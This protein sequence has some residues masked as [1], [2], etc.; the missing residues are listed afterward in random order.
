MLEYVEPKCLR[1][2]RSAETVAIK[3]SADK[4][5]AAIDLFDRI[6]HLCDQTRSTDL[7]SLADGLLYLIHGHEGPCA[8]MHGDDLCV[9]VHMRECISDRLGSCG[10]AGDQREQLSYPGSL[11]NALK[12]CLSRFTQNENYLVDVGAGLELL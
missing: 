1:R 7:L 3:R 2:E 9:R 12:V 4:L 8:V 5:K 10:T 11:G 6:R